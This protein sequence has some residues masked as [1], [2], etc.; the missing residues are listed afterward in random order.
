[1]TYP[2]ALLFIY[3][4][5]RPYPFPIRFKNSSFSLIICGSHVISW[6]IILIKLYM[7]IPF[8]SSAEKSKSSSKLWF[9][10]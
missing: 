2:P 8:I 9:S 6:P 4:S 5:S 10:P 1:M 3:V 7:E